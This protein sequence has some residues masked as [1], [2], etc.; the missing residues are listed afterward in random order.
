MTKNILFKKIYV[1]FCVLIFFAQFAFS[2]LHPL[3][4]I[5]T[6][7]NSS[8]ELNKTYAATSN[9][10]SYSV[11]GA[12]TV[13]N[14]IDI[15]INISSI[16]NLYGASVDFL[17]DTSLIEVQSITV[18]NLF[19]DKI[20]S[21]TVQKIEGGQANLAM[22]LSSS[23]DPISG[24]GTIA[25]IKAKVLKAGTINLKTTDNSSLLSLSGFA[26]CVKLA[27][28]LSS[29]IA[30]TSID[31]SITTENL[32]VILK[33]GK[34][35]NI[36]TK[37]TFSGTWIKTTDGSQHYSSTANS[38]LSFS[39]EG[40][41]IKLYSIVA[42]NR[43]ITK[44]IIDGVNYTADGYSASVASDK[45]I[46]SKDGLTFGKHDVQLIV[47]NTKNAASTGY[48]T[49]IDAVEVLNSKPPLTVGRHENISENL[50]YS[51][52]WI[53][54]TDSSQH[55][56][57]TS[58]SKV[59]FSFEGTGIKLYTI[60]ANNRGI[61]KIIIDGVAYTADGY[62]AT[63]ISK[64]VIFSKDGLAPGR[65]E[66]EIVVTS[67]KNTASSGYFVSIDAIEILSSKYI[68]NPGSYQNTS[69][70]LNYSA[71]WVKA[72]D[73]SQN[74]SN[75]NNAKITFSFEGTGIKLY[76]IVAN[77]RG[78]AKVY[79]DGI[80]YD[81]DGYSAS[82]V[83]N[84]VI[85]SKDDMPAGNHE[86]QIVVTAAKNPSSSGTYVSVDAIEIL[87]TKP[88]I[89]VGRYEN[90]DDA[91]TYSTGWTKTTD[92]SQH[93]S[94]VNNSSVSFSFTGT[95]LKLYSIIANNRGITKVIIDGVNYTADG[96]SATVAS[97]KVIFTKD[98][99]TAGKHDVQIV[100]TN[101]KNAAS[102]GY[103]TSIDA[104]EILDNQTVFN[105][106]RYEN[107]NANLDYSANWIKSA[108]S[109]QHFSNVE[110]STLSFS[111]NGT[112]LK[113][114]S[115]LAD[116]RGIAKI[117]IDG[118]EYSADTYSSTIKTNQLTFTKTGLT[119]GKHDVQIMVTNTKNAASSNYYISIDA[120]EV[121]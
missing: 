119:A 27:D 54:T 57:S 87:Q 80:P 59:S 64:K 113:L 48:F 69:E 102:T 72:A 99:L 67:S 118:V 98:D 79:I 65:H 33:Q 2:S 53:K 24:S 89:S 105:A 111:F 31:N 36:D 104:I 82:V 26:T 77:N 42:N 52:N 18:G 66:V 101:T 97:N 8:E 58:N 17:Y 29:K 68:L 60:A 73:S 3:A 74:F 85:F 115:I 40:T 43:G 81:A 56:S 70:N 120:I 103:F 112:G 55:F 106:G 94:N 62:S 63:V 10:I 114:Y 7:T 61:A 75:I 12:P 92:S 109:S 121:I 93:F 20:S 110:N 13:G 21:P 107:T 19:A 41:G 35:Q 51:A 14:T 50:T 100:A 49:S 30:Y 116:N 16:S 5:S 9:Q 45:V 91:F 78:I 47:T 32:A 46:F 4:I 6:G 88:T 108:D 15:A 38:N 95:G 117:F 71:G 28:N 90:T 1:A 23:S 83:A 44:V 37:L 39:F 84:K 96:Y 25:T 34:Y 76:S 86:V 22:T 11:A